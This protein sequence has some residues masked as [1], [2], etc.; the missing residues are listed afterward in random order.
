MES[1]VCTSNGEKYTKTKCK[2]CQDRTVVGFIGPV[3]RRIP[4]HI[5]MK[6]GTMEQSRFK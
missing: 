6:G 4:K 1:K 3:R 5:R 2:K